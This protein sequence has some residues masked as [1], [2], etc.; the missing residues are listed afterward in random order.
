MA[1]TN[2]HTYNL[3]AS[4]GALVRELWWLLPQ[5][6]FH[7]QRGNYVK[8]NRAC[9]LV[10][11]EPGDTPDTFHAGLTVFPLAS[12]PVEPDGIE[13]ALTGAVEGQP[14]VRL[15]RRGVTN[16]L[17]SLTLYNLPA[18]KYSLLLAQSLVAPPRSSRTR[19]GLAT[20]SP[21]D[22][23][24]E[25][26]I[27]VRGVGRDAA[28]FAT[29]PGALLFQEYLAEDGSLTCT[30]SETP[31]RELLLDVEA[32]PPAEGTAEATG[33]ERRA[34]AG[35]LWVEYVIAEQDSDHVATVARA[36]QPVALAGRLALTA[37]PKYPGRYTAHT[38]LG[39]RVPLPPAYDLRVYLV[40]GPA[41]EEERGDGDHRTTENLPGTGGV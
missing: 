38:S 19:G 9:V 37:G 30:L 13:I 2:G 1:K 26:P 6:V 12:E 25:S 34:E 40:P 35:P 21:A 16:H 20:S 11:T 24:A 4:L 3:T 29:H 41:S 7:T 23:P 31:E 17:G 22:R 27:R 8:G 32:M 36:G 10:D 5:V 33:G 15:L 14:H 18:G 28:G 39:Y